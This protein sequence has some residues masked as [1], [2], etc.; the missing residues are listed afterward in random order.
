VRNRLYGNLR[1]VNP[2]NPEGLVNSQKLF[3]KFYSQ[4]GL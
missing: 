3:E 4:A 2:K 1:R